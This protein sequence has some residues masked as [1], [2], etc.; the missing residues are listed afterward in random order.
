MKRIL[1]MLCVIACL[2]ALA[3][4]A[5]AADTVTVHAY[6]PEGWSDVRVWAWDDSDKNP[7]S[8]LGPATLS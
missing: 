7:T 1:A 2:F 8:L 6:V 5:L 3:V 4:P